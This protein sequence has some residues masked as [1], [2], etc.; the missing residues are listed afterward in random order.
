MAAL[1][2]AFP[3][4]IIVMDHQVERFFALLTEKQIRRGGHRS[5][6]ELEAAINAYIEATNTEPKPFRWTN[7]ADD[8]RR[9]PSLLQTHHRRTSFSYAENF[10]TRTLEREAQ[11]ARRPSPR[12][13]DPD[14]RQGEEKALTRYSRVNLSKGETNS[15]LQDVSWQQEIHM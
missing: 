9:R 7:S 3:A 6:G 14:K 13:L 2:P 10:R 15:Y 12:A 4:D 8:P 1:A 5:T 11:K